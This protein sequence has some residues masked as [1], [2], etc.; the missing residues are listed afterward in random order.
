MSQIVNCLIVD[1]EPIACEILEGYLN[2]ISQAN[3]VASCQSAIHAMEVLN[4]NSIDLVFLD[5]HMPELSGLALA[6]LIGSNTQIIFT[7]AYREYAID[8]FDLKAVDYLLKPI[9]FERFVQAFNVF[10][11]RTI[12]SLT[13]KKESTNHAIPDFLYVRSERKMTKVIFDDILFI[14]SLSDYVKIHLKDK[15]IVTR[16]KI[17]KIEQFL[18]DSFIRIHRSFIVSLVKIES[19]SHETIVILG[20]EL[21]I[22]RNCRDNVLIRLKSN[23]L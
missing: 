13:P 2:K 20:K 3:V 1:D 16:E 18:P 9:S 6:R 4:E 22:S 7:T 5:I 17:S 19:Y 8:G 15:E 21:P 14:E 23:V 10:L 12:F 11:E